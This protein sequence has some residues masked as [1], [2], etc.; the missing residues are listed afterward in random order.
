[1][2]FEHDSGNWGRKDADIVKGLLAYSAIVSREQQELYQSAVKSLIKR[3]R[4]SQG[5]DRKENIFR[6]EAERQ[7]CHKISFLSPERRRCRGK[8]STRSNFTMP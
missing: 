7:K 5:P 4:R 1:M 3:L 2:V 8:L 6:L